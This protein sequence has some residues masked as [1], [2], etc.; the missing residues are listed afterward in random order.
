MNDKNRPE[1][2]LV[3][4]LQILIFC[5]GGDF[6][7]GVFFYFGVDLQENGTQEQNHWKYKVKFFSDI[8]IQEF[9]IKYCCV[10]D[11]EGK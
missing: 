2:N 9:V 7:G 11:M 6:K 1:A 3:D 8:L 4:F 5:R 10:Y